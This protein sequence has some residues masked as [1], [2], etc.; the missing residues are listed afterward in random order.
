[1]QEFD[2]GS[3]IYGILETQ[4]RDLVR[5]SKKAIGDRVI[6]VLLIIVMISIH[7]DTNGS[8]MLI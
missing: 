8:K 4:E 1:M 3:L 5:Q 7:K 2:H 6:E